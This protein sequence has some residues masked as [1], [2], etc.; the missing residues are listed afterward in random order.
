MPI[1]SGAQIGELPY[2][3]D[4]IQTHIM[5]L[6]DSGLTYLATWLDLPAS[7]DTLD[8]DT[9][10]G[11][12]AQ[13]LSDRSQSSAKGDVV[14]PVTNAQ[15]SFWVTNEQGFLQGFV[16]NRMKDRLAILSIGCQGSDF[17]VRQKAKAIRFLSSFE[18]S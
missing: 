15:F 2:E 14:L 5:I 10:F 8:D 3:G 16:L 1:I 7:L 4:T 6:R 11:T 17:G 18:Q 13:Y 9:M 12:F